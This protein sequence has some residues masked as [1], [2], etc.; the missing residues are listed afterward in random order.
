MNKDRQSRRLSRGNLSHQSGTL[1]GDFV[2]P[3]DDPIHLL[4]SRSRL[5]GGTPNPSIRCDA[6]ERRSPL[7]SWWHQPLLPIPHPS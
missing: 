7:F 6:H 4:D 1:L 2:D 3:S 5:L